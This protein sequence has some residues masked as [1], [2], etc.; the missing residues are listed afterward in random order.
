MVAKDIYV[1]TNPDRLDNFI[2]D[3]AAYFKVVSDFMKLP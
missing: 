3:K 1:V 2:V